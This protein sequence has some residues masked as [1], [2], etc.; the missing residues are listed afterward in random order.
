MIKGFVMS[1]L[2]GAAVAVSFGG[3]AWA[4]GTEGLA[5]QETLTAAEAGQETGDTSGG[6]AVGTGI[7]DTSGEEAVEAGTRGASGEDAVGAGTGDT[8]GEDAVEAWTGDRS[9]Q[10]AAETGIGQSSHENRS[11]GEEDPEPTGPLLVM[12]KN[13]GRAQM[14]SVLIRSQNGRLIVIDGG[15]EE[16]GDYLLENIKKY[17]GHVDAWFITHPHPDHGGALCYIL[18]NKSSEITIDRIYGS[19]ASPEWYQKASPEEAPFV[20]TFLRELSMLPVGTVWG[21]VGKG[22][23]TDMD[24][25]RITALNNRYELKTDPV[26]NSS[27]VYLLETGE[28]KVLFLGDMG[29]EGGQRLLKESERMLAADM[30][31]MAHHGQNGVGKE[32]YK[33]IAPRICLWPTP[34]WLWDNDRG[35]GEGTGPWKTLETRKWIEELG[36]EENYCIKDGDIILELK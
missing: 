36:V 17:G 6:D 11:E 33:A 27:I 19:F 29:Y 31:Q 15:W 16:D 10:D 30:V 20:E 25:L 4:A 14:L 21:S 22:F 23:E 24:G 3:R 35:E 26:N 9:R 1:V 8:T 7:G 2:L 34:Q 28:Q 32:V 12:L 13:S 5:G 18:R